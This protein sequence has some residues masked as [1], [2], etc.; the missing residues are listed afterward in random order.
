M[1]LGL[2]PGI[3]S[4]GYGVVEAHGSRLRF[5]A[6]GVVRTSPRQ[7]HAE[8]LTVIHAAVTEIAR[9]HEAVAAAIEELYVGPDPRGTLLLAQARGAALAAC[10]GAGLD[11]SEYPV[12]TIKNAVCGY[13]RASK[14]QV[15]RM[16]RAI[17]ALPAD[18]RSEH[19]ADALA[20]AICQAHR[21]RAP[22]AG[23]RR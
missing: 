16:V 21:V 12:A 13:G 20:A 7:A 4:T 9:E 10:G 23:G 18:P 17:L 5:V 14:E 3:A 22:V 11:V 8:R 1:I 2:D 15:G 19:E 6:S